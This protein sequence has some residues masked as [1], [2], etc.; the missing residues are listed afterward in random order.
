MLR[1]RLTAVVPTFRGAI[2]AEYFSIFTQSYPEGTL[3]FVERQLRNAKNGHPEN[4]VSKNTY[5]EKST[6]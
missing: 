5:M 4:Q 2:A 6:G 3:G 1:I